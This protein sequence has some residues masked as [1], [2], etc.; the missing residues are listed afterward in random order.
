MTSFRASALPK[1]EGRNSNNTYVKHPLHSTFVISIALRGSGA[2]LA[3][4]LNLL[5]ARLLG[6]AQFGHYMTALSA[7]LLLGGLAVR[8]T[9]QLATREA[10][11]SERVLKRGFLRWA[12]R[13]VLYGSVA[14]S[15][16]YIVWHV[17]L[18]GG[19][20]SE[21]SLSILF[22]GPVIIALYA[23]SATVAGALNGVGATQRSQVMLLGV[24]NFAVLAALGVAWLIAGKLT[25]S[26]AALVLQTIGYFIT[27]LLGL[28]WLRS[29]AGRVPGAPIEAVSSLDCRNWA[30]SSRHLM[31]VAIA[32]M[33]INR[34]DVVLVSSIA[35][36]TVSGIY[37]AG[38]R[39][40][41]V[42]LIA[43]VSIN[44]VLSPRIAN[45]WARSDNQALRKLVVHGFCFT[46]PV[47]VAMV[48]A[49]ALLAPTVISFLGSEYVESRSVFIFV[50]VANGLW[51]ITAPAYVLLSMTGAE[52]NAAM[53]SWLVVFVNA[54]AT[55]LFVPLLGAKGAG[56]AMCI[57]Y[58]AV[59]PVLA[60]AI[61]RRL[62]VLK[63]MDN[64]PRRARLPSTASERYVEDQ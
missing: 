56:M 40:A 53:I 42:T 44:A 35:G 58:S 51:T 7:A 4:V 30:V 54:T 55:L 16:A 14:A 32:A 26:G 60:W 41:Q 64:L 50:A 10:S 13:R 21:G 37:A 11:A 31:L 39:L 34:F 29:H 22:L 18:R 43:G 46:T 52:S 17:A 12:A 27:L 6:A 63:M 5:F 24:K 8:G 25:S 1:R 15:A 2:F 62:R 38:A 61:V 48:L 59:L 57:G 47:A 3:L 19:F 23:S 33:L 49:A 9:D 36:D 20:V 28:Q 45:A